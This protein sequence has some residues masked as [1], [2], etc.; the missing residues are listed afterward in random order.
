M[1]KWAIWRMVHRRS[2][3]FAWGLLG[4]LASVLLIAPLRGQDIERRVSELEQAHPDRRLSVIEAKLENLDFIG[5]GVLIA[6]GGQ[7]IL[8][9]FDLRSRKSDRS[10]RVK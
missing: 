9:V 2:N 6:V 8:T 10:W 7:L 1:F 4:L 5:R 3:L